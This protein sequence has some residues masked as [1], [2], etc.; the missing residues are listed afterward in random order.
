MARSWEPRW[1]L[2]QHL[3]RAQAN[4]MATVWATE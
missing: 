4:W 3:E 1:E 2:A